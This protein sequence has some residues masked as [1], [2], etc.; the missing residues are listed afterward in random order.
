MKKG[1]AQ[2]RTSTLGQFS[3]YDEDE[4]RTLAGYDGPS[5]PETIEEFWEEHARH[6]V[7]YKRDDTTGEAALAECSSCYGA[8][9]YL[10]A[11]SAILGGLLFEV[12]EEE[13]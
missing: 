5:R 11:F 2:W 4:V 7:V 12:R 10:N 6:G 9:L 1:R 8:A 3:S 13:E